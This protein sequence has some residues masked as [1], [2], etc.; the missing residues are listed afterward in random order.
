MLLTSEDR[1]YSIVTEQFDKIC[2]ESIKLSKNI[3]IL[4]KRIEKNYSS[5]TSEGEESEMCIAD[6]DTDEIEEAAQIEE[7]NNSSE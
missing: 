3:E 1:K 2:E 6:E 5:E 4:V 7:E